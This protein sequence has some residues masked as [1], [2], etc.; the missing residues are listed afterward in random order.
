[1]K[2]LHL[3]LFARL[4]LGLLFSSNLTVLA[5]T[6]TVINLND[7][8]AD[9][10]RAVI[11]SSVSGDTVAFNSGLTGTIVLTSGQLVITNN[12]TINGPGPST[13]AVSGNNSNRVFMIND[14]ISVNISGLTIC[15][16]LST[17]MNGVDLSASCDVNPDYKIQPAAGGDGIG[18]GILNNGALSLSNC[19]LSGNVASGGPGGSG[20][21]L[22]LNCNNVHYVVD[23]YGTNGGVGLG[24]AIWNGGYLTTVECSFSNNLAVGGVGGNGDF[25]YNGGDGGFSAG[26]AVFNTYHWS[27]ANCCFSYNSANGGN[28]GKGGYYGNTIVQILPGTGGNGLYA[29]GGAIFSKNECAITNSTF[30]LNSSTGGSGGQGGDGDTFLNVSGGT[31][32]NG[33]DASGGALYLFPAAGSVCRIYSCTISSNGVYKGSAGPGGSG[34]PIGTSGNLGL[35][36][37]G[38][39]Y[40]ASYL[41]V[42]YF[43]NTIVAWNTL[44]LF[45]NVKDGADMFQNPI[46]QG[47]NLIGIT[48]GSSGW[49]ST[50]KTGDINNPLDPKL[51]PLRDNGGLTYTTALLS[52]SPAID[53]GTNNAGSKDQRGMSRPLDISIISNAPGGDGS[54][55]GAYEATL[56]LDIG[57]RAFDGTTAKKIAAEYPAASSLRLSK[58]GTNYGIALTATNSADAS[59]FRI[60]T[61]SGIKAWQTLP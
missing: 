39:V 30:C 56:T 55:I 43:Q 38:G 33:G 45:A 40:N 34:Q 58:N 22:G 5:T 18:G 53:K 29:L 27:A 41:T 28:G 60:Q 23:S 50:D 6:N 9:S 36:F 61:A 49:I 48:N 57:L 14:S 13:L 20:T 47:F 10:L 24:G 31:G 25:R 7:S 4:G 19:T 59:R 44:P 11:N 32:G 51:G 17:G 26:G 15:N 37:G 12:L 54:D 42:I 46:S 1:M 16:G 52:G 3:W 8:G 2:N 21:G 35:V